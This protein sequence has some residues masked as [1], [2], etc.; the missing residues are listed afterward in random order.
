MP[1]IDYIF[2]YNFQQTKSRLK[3]YSGGI[4]SINF[5]Q[6][7]KPKSSA[8]KFLFQVAATFNHHKLAAINTDS[9]F[10][11]D[12]SHKATLHFSLRFCNFIIIEA[13]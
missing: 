6:G 7:A 12:K 5:N 8:G 4:L 2:L 13:V 1:L 3:L 10:L 11:Y 9:C